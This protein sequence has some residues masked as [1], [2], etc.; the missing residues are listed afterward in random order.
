VKT[1]LGYQVSHSEFESPFVYDLILSSFH[2]LEKICDWS[3]CIQIAVKLNSAL[4][5][6][7]IMVKKVIPVDLKI[8]Q[9]GL[10]LKHYLYVRYQCQD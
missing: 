4:Q 6:V 9:N 2:P 10:S 1:V 7:T 3:P 8:I 5:S